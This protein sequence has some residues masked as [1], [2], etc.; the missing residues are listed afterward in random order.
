MHTNEHFGEGGSP[1][2]LVQSVLTTC[3]SLYIQTV[4]FKGSKPVMFLLHNKLFIYAYTTYLCHKLSYR[5]VC[6]A[7]L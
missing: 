3:V 5:S 7:T 4:T 6:Y 2:S 1:G